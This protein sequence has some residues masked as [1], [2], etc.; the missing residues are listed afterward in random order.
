MSV[1]Y[2][3]D[4]RYPDKPWLAEVYT[5]GRRTR[6]RA[7]TRREAGEVERGL[8]ARRLP[9]RG[10]EAAL[11]EYLTV[12]VPRLR[13]PAD[14]K[15]HARALR[16]F[17]AGRHFDDVPDIVRELRKAHH[18][19]S[20][21]T[22]NRRL[23]LLRR[24]GNLAEEWGWVERAPKIR[25][26]AESGRDAV[27]TPAQVD[28]LAARM[29]RAGGMFLLCAYTGLRKTEAM[30]LTAESVHDDGV[31]VE[32]LKQR[33]RTVA[34]VPVPTRV[35]HLL[36]AL[37]FAVTEQIV[38]EEW[39]AAR[40]AEGLRHVRWHDTRHTYASWLA[41]RGVSDRELSALLRH[42]DPRM[43]ARYAHLRPDHLRGVVDDL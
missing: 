6:R 33:K 23:A 3:P 43:V 22:L 15:S 11:L 41:A 2:K 20:R 25:L 40:A 8:H 12:Y 30:S 10:I 27:L 39:E 14:P 29:P 18:H 1:R 24:L 42:T 9:Q 37:P 38:R 7:R 36:A 16:P 5:D 19:L 26:D 32:T 13:K 21:A 17:I 34:W 31:L 35:R 28:A 4:P